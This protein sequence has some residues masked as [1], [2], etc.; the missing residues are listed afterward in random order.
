[1]AE[2]PIAAV[3][4]IIRKAGGQRVS[5]SAAEELADVL[6]EKGLELAREAVELTEHAGRKTVRDEDI[7]LAMRKTE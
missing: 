1:M 4:R 6:E 2:L 7:R 3:D 5:E